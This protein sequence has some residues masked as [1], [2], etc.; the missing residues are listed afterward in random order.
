MSS[1][2]C[3]T[4]LGYNSIQTISVLVG[5]IHESVGPARDLPRSR[6]RRHHRSIHRRSAYKSW[7]R[8]SIC[9]PSR[10]RHCLLQRCRVCRPFHPCNT[11]S[12]C[13]SSR[14][15]VRWFMV[16]QNCWFQRLTIHGNSRH[17]MNHHRR[18]S[19]QSRDPCRRWYRSSPCPPSR[20]H[21]YH[22]LHYFHR[23]LS[24]PLRSRPHWN[25][26]L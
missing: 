22:L 2:L 6:I 16:R 18:H 15:M 1:L 4:L 21:C 26:S 14:P 3:S 24:S 8:K 20:C 9:R 19:K 5:R 25:M 23:L 10:C 7:C 12:G 17:S 13:S 11:Q